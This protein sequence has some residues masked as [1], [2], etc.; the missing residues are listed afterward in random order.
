[1]K[2][3]S[4]NLNLG[5]Y[6]CFSLA[7]AVLEPNIGELPASKKAGPM[8]KVDRLP[9]PSKRNFKTLPFLADVSSGLS[10]P[11][12]SGLGHFSVHKDLSV[13]FSSF[14]QMYML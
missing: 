6:S 13:P 12:L 9:L 11:V 1:M 10:V 7:E 5:D 2:L 14:V 8:C 4:F 3:L